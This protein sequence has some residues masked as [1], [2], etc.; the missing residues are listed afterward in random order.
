MNWGDKA[1]SALFTFVLA[2][3]LGPRDFGV[4]AIALIYVVFIQMFLDQG[5]VSAIIQR[6]DLQPRHLDSVFWLNVALCAVLMGLSILLSGWWARANRL[7]E[8]ALVISVLSLALPLE[9]LAIVQKALLQRE[10]DF[11]S[12]SLRSNFSVLIGGAIGVVMALKGFGVW[13]LVGQRLAQDLAALGLLWTLSHWRPGWR[14]SWESLKEILSFSAQTFVGKIGTF[15]HEQADALLMGLFFGPVAVGLYRLAQRLMYLVLD[16]ATSSLQV[17]SLSQFSKYQSDPPELRRSVLAFIRLSAIVTLPALAGMAMTSDLIMATIGPQW[18]LAANPLKV[19]S[20]YGVAISF[21]M[22]TGPLLVAR[23]RPLAMSLLTWVSA[24]V[25]VGALVVAAVWL[26]GAAPNWQVTGIALARLA[27][28]AVLM[29]PLYVY[30]LMRHSGVSFAEF[31]KHVAP[32]FVAAGVVAI[33]VQTLF[34]TAGGILQAQKPIVCLAVVVVIGGAI[35]I[36][37][38]LGLDAQ[39]RREVFALYGRVFRGGESAAS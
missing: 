2:A 32:A 15:V 36:A 19:L 21:A 34:L 10:M 20:C 28:G 35:G 16:S 6:K 23:G 13:A 3:I 24:A 5:L 39:I 18:A 25:N 33:V 11:K 4:V 27:V 22:F 30:I 7:P 1:F 17:V 9:G 29:A 31:F 38:I 8:L 14:F 26:S 12:L 37:A